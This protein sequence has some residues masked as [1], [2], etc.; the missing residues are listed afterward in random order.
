MW[1]VAGK[2]YRVNGLGPILSMRYA[3]RPTLIALFFHFSFWR[4]Q[5]M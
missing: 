3:P 1:T 4:S 5:R 2:L